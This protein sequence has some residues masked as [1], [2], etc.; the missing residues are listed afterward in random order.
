[1]TD[2]PSTT[3]TAYPRS[4]LPPIAATRLRPMVS[5]DGTIP[6]HGISAIQFDLFLAIPEGTSA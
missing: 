1:M 6:A 4:S 2:E 5:A 3:A